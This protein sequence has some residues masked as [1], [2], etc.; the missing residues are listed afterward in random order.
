M[1]DIDENAKNYVN[2]EHIS[3][4]HNKRGKF[5]YTRTTLSQ[6]V[7]ERKIN[8]DSVLK[9]LLGENRS[10]NFVSIAVLAVFSEACERR[11]ARVGSEPGIH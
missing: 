5:H 2:L 10:S 7:F 8:F 6:Q 11:R 9:V 1:K 4:I 3:I